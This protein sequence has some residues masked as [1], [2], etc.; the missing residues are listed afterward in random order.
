M[1]MV[2]WIH[3]YAICVIQRTCVFIDLMNHVCQPY[4]DKFIIVFIDDIL[5]YTKNELDHAEH[6]HLTL[7]L[8]KN[9]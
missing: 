4:L 2:I 9:E 3:C 7:E 1:D 8:S 6:F 5:I